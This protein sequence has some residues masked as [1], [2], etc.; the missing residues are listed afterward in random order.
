MEAFLRGHPDD[1]PLPLERPIDNVN[2]KINVLNST[3]D[4]R[5]TPLKRSPSLCKK[6]VASQ[7]GFRCIHTYK[8]MYFFT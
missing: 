5:P 7:E 2:L 1:R 8:Y 4:E 3:S 6:G